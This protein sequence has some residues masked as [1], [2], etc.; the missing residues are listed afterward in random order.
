[1]A[2]SP[3]K[4]DTPQKNQPDAVTE[5]LDKAL[6]L[7]KK[8]MLIGLGATVQA[9]ERLKAASEE[10]VAS[11]VS[12]GTINQSQARLLS[13]DLRDTLKA[14]R[15]RVE[16]QMSDMAET[17]LKKMIDSLGLVTRDDL[18]ALRWELKK[19]RSGPTGAAGAP[20]SKKP[21]RSGRGS[22]PPRIKKTP[23]NK[24]SAPKAR[25]TSHAASPPSA[26]SAPTVRGG[27]KSPGAGK[28]KGRGKSTPASRAI[29]GR[30][31]S[32]RKPSNKR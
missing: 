18:D 3:Q 27:K 5:P 14:E 24:R 28:H 6:L 26:P 10:V 1:M 31:K 25:T 19:T 7:L 21:T 4:P 22:P 13:R 29:A 2:D 12:Q 16:Q 9:T 20:P 32:A 23:E 15:L 17:T 11:L 30:E 8:G